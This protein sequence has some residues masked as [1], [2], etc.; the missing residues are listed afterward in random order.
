M[1]GYVNYM[2][3]FKNVNFTFYFSK[4]VILNWLHLGILNARVK[5]LFVCGFTV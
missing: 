5:M 4:I 2:F 1:D 3:I